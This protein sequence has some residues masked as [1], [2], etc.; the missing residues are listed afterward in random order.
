MSS[1]LFN[2]MKDYQRARLQLLSY[3]LDF[4]ASP[5]SVKKHE[6]AAA[7]DP[8]EKADASFILGSLVCRYAAEE[9]LT[10][11]KKSKLEKFWHYSVFCNP[12]VARLSLTP[13]LRYG[14]STPDYLVEDGSGEWYAVEAKGTFGEEDW[15]PI[16][17]GLNQARNLKTLTYW[18]PQTPALRIKKLGDFACS[19]AYFDNAEKLTITYADPPDIAATSPQGD[20]EAIG[21]VFEFAELANLHQAC[22]QFRRLSRRS[23]RYPPLLQQEKYRWGVLLEGAD[24]SS[25]V[26]V[27]IHRSLL[28]KERLIHDILGALPTASSMRTIRWGRH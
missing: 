28:A 4:S 14:K 26:F 11:I 16:R 15:R 9:W 19:L 6:L 1:G 20:G 21:I 8:S 3:L 27:G 7:L 12:A 24:S 5:G 23:T 18:D 10:K 17:D 13:S 22:K 2:R 25:V